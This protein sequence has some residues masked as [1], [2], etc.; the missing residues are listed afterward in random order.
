MNDITAPATGL[1]RLW[2]RLA[3]PV[4][5]VAAADVLVGL[6]PANARQ[7]LAV[8]LAASPEADEL[9]ENMPTV[10]RSL[11]VSTTARPV[12]CEGELRGPV[13][14]SET[15]AARSASPGAGGVYICA[16]PIK[17][18]D[19]DE[20]RIL[21]AALLRIQRAARAAESPEQARHAP[22]NDDLRRAR[23]NG[24]LARRALEHRSLQ[25]VSRVPPTGRMML[26]A[27]TGTKASVFRTAV[28]LLNRS[29]AE[30]GADDLAPFVDADTRV[31]HAFAADVVDLLVAHDRLQSRLRLEGGM[32]VGGPFAYGHPRREAARRDGARGGVYVDDRRIESLT[33]L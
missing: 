33:E 4:D 11:A 7:L 28:G 30:V 18:Y 15:M 32:L 6:R 16:S 29:W 26:K 14:W 25:L 17:A 24:E 12:R 21:V 10:L 9:L 22:R 5:P 31:E 20:N 8:A 1:Q 13:L 19:T 23:H 3:R 2:R 27:R